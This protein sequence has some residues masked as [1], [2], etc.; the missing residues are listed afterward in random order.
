MTVPTTTL[1]PVLLKPEEAAKMLRI[2]RSKLYE[3][4]AARELTSIKIG[5]S[6]RVRLADVAAYI[7]RRAAAD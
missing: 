6:R 7:E 3:L 5:R 2:G 4:L 1:H